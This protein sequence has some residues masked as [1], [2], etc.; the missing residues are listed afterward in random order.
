MAYSWRRADFGSMQI[1]AAAFVCLMAATSGVRAG[2]VIGP[3]EPPFP[4]DSALEGKLKAAPPRDDRTLGQHP[5]QPPRL[6]VEGGRPPRGRVCFTQA[7]TR[8]NIIAHRLAD[9]VRA[10]R[11]GRLQGEALTAKLCRWTPDQF[12]YE[13]YVLRRDGRVLR[14]YMNA[15]SGEAVGGQDLPPGWDKDHN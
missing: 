6:R 14:V 12:V 2:D 13:I 3:V 11:M 10:L 5:V 7:E 1:A 15:Q 9:P 4:P 8:D